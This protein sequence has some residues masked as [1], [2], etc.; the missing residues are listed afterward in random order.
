MS[1]SNYFSHSETS[2]TY[3]YNYPN[4]RKTPKHLSIILQV[5]GIFRSIENM[6][7]IL[8]G[9]SEKN[10][11]KIQSLRKTPNSYFIYFISIG[12]FRILVFLCLIASESSEYL[13][14]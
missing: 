7:L 13:Y 12:K 10:K 3:L 2:E 6:I 4:L 8:S 11:S 14:L 1:L 9:I 5:F